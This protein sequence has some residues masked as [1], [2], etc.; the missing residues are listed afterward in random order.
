MTTNRALAELKLASALNRLGDDPVA[1]RI[2]EDLEVLEKRGRERVAVNVNLAKLKATGRQL[3]DAARPVLD[4]LTVVRAD[5]AVMP[6]LQRH[7]DNARADRERELRAELELAVVG[8]MTEYNVA[9]NNLLDS[10]PEP[11]RRLPDLTG[12]DANRVSALLLQF[13]LL[14]PVERLA[15]FEEHVR[16]LDRPAVHLTLALA[17]EALEAEELATAPRATLDRLHGVVQLGEGLLRVGPDGWKSFAREEA[18]ER[19]HR[20]RA[21]VETV[22]ETIVGEGSL[23]GVEMMARLVASDAR[24]DDGRPVARPGGAFPDL[25]PIFDDPVG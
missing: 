6:E 2:A 20:I 11:E 15:A 12:D 16:R 23:T 19:G 5:A 13:Q 24:D 3:V 21:Q 8:V 17:R 4:E 1:R 10:F 9:E 18:I 25:D 7:T 22:A 14:G